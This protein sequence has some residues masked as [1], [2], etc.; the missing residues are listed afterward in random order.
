M[1]GTD[2]ISDMFNISLNKF[3]K[4]LYDFSLWVYSFGELVINGYIPSFK[5]TYY[6]TNNP[7]YSEE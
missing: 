3:L 2:T 5:I 6:A 7:N 4:S 1:T